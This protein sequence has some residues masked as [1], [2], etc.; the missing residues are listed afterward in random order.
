MMV[1]KEST[2]NIEITLIIDTNYTPKSP[3]TMMM[4]YGNLHSKKMALERFQGKNVNFLSY[5]FE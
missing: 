5:Y 3:N 4:N 1:G 2:Q